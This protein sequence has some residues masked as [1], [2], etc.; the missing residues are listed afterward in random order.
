MDDRRDDRVS[1]MP[2]IASVGEGLLFG[3]L[4][5]DRSL[6]SLLEVDCATRS[7]KR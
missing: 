5:L 4:E 7:A 1:E 6:H 2:A 3:G